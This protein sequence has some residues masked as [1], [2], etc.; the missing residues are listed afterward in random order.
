MSRFSFIT[1]SSHGENEG[2][3]RTRERPKF[4]FKGSFFTEKHKTKEMDIPL[5]IITD[6]PTLRFKKKILPCC[7][8]I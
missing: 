1:P 8:H 3:S 2:Q 5:R 6:H 4:Y 7:C